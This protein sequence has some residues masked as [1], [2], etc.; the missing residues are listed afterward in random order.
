MYWLVPVLVVVSLV[1]GSDR[2]SI[3]VNQMQCQLVL[4]HS[5]YISVLHFLLWVQS[6]NHLHHY[7]CIHQLGTS[8]C[9][10]NRLYTHVI[11]YWLYRSNKMAIIVAMNVLLL[12]TYQGYWWVGLNLHNSMIEEICAMQPILYSRDVLGLFL[13]SE[14]GFG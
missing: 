6:Q 2:P 7:I 4:Y 12:S 9:H 8:Y 11:V 1:I 14:I 10:A 13:L 3:P 5:G